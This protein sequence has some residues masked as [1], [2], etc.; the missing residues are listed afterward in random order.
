MDL[1]NL[2]PD[3]QEEILFLPRTTVGRD[4]VSEGD[5]RRV[6][7][8]VGSP[9][10]L[11]RKSGPREREEECLRRPWHMLQVCTEPTSV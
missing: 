2:A 8:E 5:V 10:S 9:S 11:V 1:L 3:I 6:A 7:G 4:G